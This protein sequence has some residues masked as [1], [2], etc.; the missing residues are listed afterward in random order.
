MVDCVAVAGDS[1]STVAPVQVRVRAEFGV[2]GYHKAGDEWGSRL[3]SANSSSGIWQG[4]VL[5]LVRRQRVLAV[6]CLCQQLKKKKKI[7]KLVVQISV[8]AYL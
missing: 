5:A 8:C 7:P 6:F 3:I 2:M 4:V 1:T